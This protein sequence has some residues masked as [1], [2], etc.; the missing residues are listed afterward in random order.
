[1]AGGILGVPLSSRAALGSAYI[2]LSG[3]EF[4]YEL[5]QHESVKPLLITVH[6]LARTAGSLVRCGY[7]LP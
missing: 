6:S 4:S 3:R 5:L 1:V 7:Q 2:E